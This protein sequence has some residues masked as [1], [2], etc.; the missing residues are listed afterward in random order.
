MRLLAHLLLVVVS[1]ALARE[2]PPAPGS[3]LERVQRIRQADYAGDR[4]ALRRLYAELAARPEEPEHAAELR[5][6]RGFALWR[7]AINGFNETPT[8]E[9]LDADLEAAV[10][11]FEVALKA[12]PKFVD[13]Q[14]GL[15]S[16]LG[17]RMFLRGRQDEQ[18]RAFATR[19]RT[20]L[21]EADALEPEN[22]R[23]LWVRGPTE[24]WTP[25]GSPPETVDARQAK[26]IAT[27]ARG[28]EALRRAG[29]QPASGSLRPT[30]GEAELEMSLAWSLLKR[31]V[32]DFAQAE[33]HAR[34]ALALV[35]TWHYVRDI[36]VPQIEAARRT[37]IR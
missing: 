11:E 12:D 7:R 9:D 33:A 14:A 3:T 13:A 6:W 32:P 27:Y 37:A 35:P 18:T 22:P 28:L 30:W 10:A 15:A 21:A 34:K 5:Y 20:L 26:A 2:R 19:V 36:L 17:M 23:L 29:K 1:A 25:K 24:W 4:P 31:R 8:P 16:C